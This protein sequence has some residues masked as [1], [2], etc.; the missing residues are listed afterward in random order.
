M[1]LAGNQIR[2]LPRRSNMTLSPSLQ[3]VT[4]PV[5][6]PPVVQIDRAQPGY[7]QRLCDLAVAPERLWVRGRLPAPS[8][9]LV[10]MVGSRAASGDG[11]AKAKALA[12]DLGRAGF[13][14]VSGGAFGVDAAAHE[15]A[16]AVGAPTYAVLGCGIDI[17]Y[18]DRHANL[19]ARIA[20]TGGVLSEYDLGTQPRPGQFPARNRI[21][22]ALAEAV[23]VVEAA[24]RSGALITAGCATHLRRPLAAVPG[25]AGT[26][27]LIRS[28]QAVGVAAAEDV[29]AVLRGAVVRSALADEPGPHDR[30]LSAIDEG[31]DTPMLLCRSLGLTLAEVLAALALAELD[32]R[33]RRA[34]AD[35]YEVADCAC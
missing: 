22:A 10:A 25:S 16:L 17:A 2:A 21:I 18:P 14:I 35:T 9:R 34:G 7:P 30:L 23:I 12:A 19:F 13:G 20:V 8:E 32:G 6:A 24:A 28:R 33:V 11:C 26:H 3:P 27:A 4:L 15:G 5:G 31:A 1:E 29:L